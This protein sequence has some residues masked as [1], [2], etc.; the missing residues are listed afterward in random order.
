MSG[1]CLLNECWKQ[2][3]VGVGRY[4][5]KE[6]ISSLIIQHKAHGWHIYNKRQTNTKKIYNILLKFY[7]TW[8]ISEMKTWAKG[9]TVVKSSQKRGT[10]Q[11]SKLGVPVHCSKP[12]W[13][14][15]SLLRWSRV[16]CIWE[17]RELLSEEEGRGFSHALRRRRDQRRAL[18]SCCLLSF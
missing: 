17:S 8:K 16:P 2:E 1:A 12:S 7:L 15:F 4:R 6:V 11:H 9:K 18:S 10:T 13:P 3:A 5:W 14:R